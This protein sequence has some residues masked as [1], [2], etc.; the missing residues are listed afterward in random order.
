MYKTLVL[1]LLR[2]RPK[3]HDYLKKSGTLLQAMEL[4][5]IELKS[6]HATYKDVIDKMKPGSDSSQVAA[7]ALELALQDL[8]D[9]LPNEIPADSNEPIS[10]DKIMAYLRGQTP[11][12]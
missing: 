11:P 4:Q 2:E 10:L 5:A 1:Q 12:G 7:E 3:L 9:R 8:R 6:H